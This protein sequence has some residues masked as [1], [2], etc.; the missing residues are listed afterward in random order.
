MGN[1]LSTEEKIISLTLVQMHPNIH[2]VS[3][4][5]VCMLLGVSIL[6]HTQPKLQ[7]DF[8]QFFSLVSPIDES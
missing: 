3:R 5:C 7:N 1:K 2:L 8:P 4:Q 6:S